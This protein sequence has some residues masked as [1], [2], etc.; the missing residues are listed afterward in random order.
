MK[1]FKF[2]IYVV[3]AVMFAT[4][5]VPIATGNVSVGD[6]ACLVH[7]ETTTE[8]TYSTKDYVPVKAD[9]VDYYNVVSEATSGGVST[10]AHA[11]LAVPLKGDAIEFN[12]QFKLLST[13]SVADGGDATDSWL[14][15]SFSSSAAGATDS[16]FP[17]YGSA[18]YGYFLHITN[19]SK[20][21]L[22][23]VEVQ[24][25]EKGD[26]TTIIQKDY[27]DNAVG[28]P[29]TISLKKAS[30]D[31]L[32]D[33]TFTRISDGS[34]L[35]TM[36]DLALTDSLFMSGTGQTYVSNAF[37]CACGGDCSSHRQVQF[38]SIKAHTKD[39][40][41]EEV[42]LSQD[43]YDYTENTTYTP[44]VTVTLDGSVLDASSNYTV[45]YSNN[46]AVGTA[47][48]TVKFIGSEYAG[49]VIEKNF[50]IRSVAT[51]EFTS[52]D[53]QISSTKYALTD[54]VTMPTA[55]KEGQI[56]LGW[57]CGGKL[58]PEGATVSLSDLGAVANGTITVKA[59]YIELSVQ[60]GASVRLNEPYGLR[61]R[62]YFSKSLIDTVDAYEGVT[63][64]FGSTITSEGSSKS[65]TF[66]G[67]KGKLYEDEKEG[68]YYFNTA[69]T[70]IKEKNFERVYY[71]TPYIT[72]EYSNGDT[73]TFT[74]TTSEGRTYKGVVEAAYIDVVDEKTDTYCYE[75][76]VGEET[77]YAKISAAAYAKLT[78]IYNGFTA[79]EGE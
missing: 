7:A 45:S 9:M 51:V 21:N 72:I 41:A 55:T 47:T 19:V 35:K 36:S 11:G 49:N 38:N 76:K 34:V 1:R 66:V 39:I 6:E 70:D 71:S 12:T 67:E 73:K 5:S 32:Y 24:V 69:I 50:T 63:V 68:C 77:K 54:S 48:A 23:C 4:A 13:Q 2:G 15:Y 31:S 40:S 42:S 65:I 14:T 62:G 17:Y 46:D 8:R 16:T 74:A 64:T 52:E 59:V 22:N 25:V 56:L 37:Y 57:E 29:I 18:G 78:E 75:V 30:D 61:F 43:V 26:S 3:L 33:L 79:E 10:F 58:Y 53:T 20:T 60:N 27:L 28:V 44:D